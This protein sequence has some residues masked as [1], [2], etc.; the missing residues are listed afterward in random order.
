MAWAFSSLYIIILMPKQAVWGLMRNN[1]QPSQVYAHQSFKREVLVSSQFHNIFVSLAGL[2]LSWSA[3][4]SGISLVLE[5]DKTLKEPIA[6]LFTTLRTRLS[7]TSIIS[8]LLA[9]Q[10]QP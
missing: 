5:K 7:R 3:S 2:S 6:I 8:S 9:C 10:H 1:Q 4:S